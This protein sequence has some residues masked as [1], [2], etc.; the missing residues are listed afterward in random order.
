M[1][2]PSWISTYQ[3]A[4]CSMYELAIVE[5][6]DSPGRIRKGDAAPD[7]FSLTTERRR[8]IGMNYEQFKAVFANALLPLGYANVKNTFFRRIGDVFLIVDLQ[9]SD[10]GGSYYVNLGLFLDEGSSLMQPPPF[11]KSHLMQRL[12][13]IISQS[14][15]NELVPALDLEVPMAANKRTSLVMNAVEQHVL[16]YLTPLGT[17]E[18]IADHLRPGG[19]KPALVTLRLRDIIY[20][21]TGD[22]TV[23]LPEQ[24]QADAKRS[25]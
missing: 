18:G 14:D 7:P 17:I 1:S 8:R 11:H 19:A 3:N 6:D 4:G 12:E 2:T 10:F 25:G 15:R 9:K 16:P 23:L 13:A 5:R 21:R 20:R 24:R 22:P